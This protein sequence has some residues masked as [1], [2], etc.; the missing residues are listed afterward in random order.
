MYNL[1]IFEDNTNC[2]LALFSI[3]GPVYLLSAHVI[4]KHSIPL[5]HWPLHVIYIH[6]YTSQFLLS[7]RFWNSNFCLDA[8]FGFLTIF[9][10]TCFLVISIL[11]DS[12][13]FDPEVYEIGSI[14]LMYSFIWQIIVGFTL[15][16]VADWH[17]WLLECE[18]HQR[19]FEYT[20]YVEMKRREYTEW[21][22][23]KR[24]KERLSF[25]VWIFLEFGFGNLRVFECRAWYSLSLSI[26][27]F[28]L[29]IP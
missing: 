23:G 18:R 13:H 5:R 22:M 6:I 19:W 28:I 21:R 29:N 14:W 3:N 25:Q 2:F 17:F 10:V 8:F 12:Q 16:E 7:F 15:K 26:Y 27:N 1:T 20:R 11:L 4:S 9:G 24:Q